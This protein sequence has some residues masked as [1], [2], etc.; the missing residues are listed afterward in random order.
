MMPASRSQKGP[1]TNI[2][3]SGLGPSLAMRPQALAAL[4]AVIDLDDD[5]D[6][7]DDLP[8]Q[9]AAV[10]YVSATPTPHTHNR[11][12]A[13]VPA[14]RPVQ[15][16]PAGTGAAPARTT[17]K[18]QVMMTTQISPAVRQLLDSYARAHRCTT[19][20][21]IDRISIPPPREQFRTADAHA[22][23]CRGMAAGRI[24]E[25]GGPHVRLSAASRG[26]F[27]SDEIHEAYVRGA[28]AGRLRR[29]GGR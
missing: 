27:T 8:E 12:A 15:H 29:L 4:L 1:D 6:L 25:C 23:Y 26:D 28:A 3:T 2:L 21:A 10:R 13:S 20:E 24:Q 18:E 22:G 9:S 14:S 11:P 5:G 16:R 17:R 19:D 7:L